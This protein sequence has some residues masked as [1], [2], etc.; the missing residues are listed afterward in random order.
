MKRGCSLP[1]SCEIPKARPARHQKASIGAKGH[2]NLRSCS[3]GTSG[4]LQVSRSTPTS[5]PWGQHRGGFGDFRGKASYECIRSLVGWH[6]VSTT[7]G[8]FRQRKGVELERR[9]KQVGSRAN[10]WMSVSTWDLKSIKDPVISAAPIRILFA[11][12]RHPTAACKGHAQ[13]VG[14]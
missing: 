10:S 9:Y 6:C 4:A 2:R 3:F 12:E 13:L 11:A 5:R 1:R 14:E 7:W 8:Q